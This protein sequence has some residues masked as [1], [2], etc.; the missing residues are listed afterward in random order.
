MA[1]RG[2][3]LYL[4]GNLIKCQ[5]R[6]QKC[7]CYALSVLNI[8]KSLAIAAVAMAILIRTSVV[9]VPSLDRV[10]LYFKLVTSSSF[11]PFMVMSAPMLFVLL[12]MIFDFSVL[13]FILYVPALS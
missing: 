4:M 12:T 3:K 8:Y 11:L 1:W 10:A 5:R 9:L 2:L 7:C 6:P 13:T